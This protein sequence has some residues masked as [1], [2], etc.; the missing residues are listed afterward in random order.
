[1]TIYSHS[2]L[3]IFGTC[4]R[5]YW[6][7][8]IERPDIE[9][10]DTVEA[11]L[12]SRVHDALEALYRALLGG[13]R[14]SREELIQWYEAEWDRQWHEGVRIV[15]PDFRARDYCEVGRQCLAGYYDGHQPFNQDR[16]LALER[17]VQIDLDEAG[18]YRMRGIIDRLTQRTDGTYEIH[19]YKTANWLMT[20]GAADTD[21]QLALYQIGVQGMWDDVRSVDLVWHFL[22][23]GKEIRS[24]R[25]PE[26]LEALKAQSIAVIDDIES[27]GKEVNNF[28]TQSSSLCDWCDYRE[29]C[30]ATKHYVAVESLPPKEYKADEGVGLVDRWAALRDQR[31]ELEEKAAAIKEEEEAVQEEILAF[32]EQHGLESVAG[33]S[34]HVDITQGI[35]IEYPKAGDEGREVFEEALRAAGL[36]DEVITLNWQ[37]LKSLWLAEDALSPEAREALRPFIE[38]YT[39]RQARLKKGSIAEE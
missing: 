2:R 9:V 12:G 4:P 24:R 17:M 11:F 18:K 6:F 35:R 15:R 34:Y 31:R 19:D 27:R 7:A 29:L 28:P 39:E 16:T 36:W 38:E 1:M 8:Y 30:P 20:Q 3:A 10:P 21:R 13:R 32:A 5:Q 33:S 22:R 23:F 37:K 25:S 14:M 26:Q